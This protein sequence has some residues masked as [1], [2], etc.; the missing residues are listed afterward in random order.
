MVL[1]TDIFIYPSPLNHTAQ[2]IR[3]YLDDLKQYDHKG[4]I[5]EI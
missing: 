5:G 2:V 4:D 3:K 1:V